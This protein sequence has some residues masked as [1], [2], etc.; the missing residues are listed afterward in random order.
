VVAL[1]ST[2]SNIKQ[3]RQCMCIVILRR[4]SATIVEV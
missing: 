1:F 3:D 2:C 4:A